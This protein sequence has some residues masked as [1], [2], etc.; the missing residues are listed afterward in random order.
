MAAH[1]LTTVA[2]VRAFLQTPGVDTE[3]DAIAQT[4]ISALSRAISAHCEQE[5]APAVT[6]AE[7]E[8]SYEC[9]TLLCNL[10]PYS[11]RTLTAVDVSDDDGTTWSSFLTS[12]VRRL[13]RPAIHGVFNR[14]KF[15]AHPQGD[16]VRV[17]G[18][19][20]YEEVPET[21]AHVCTIETALHLRRDVA[22][23][24][25]TL[26]L[27]VQALERPDALSPVAV[28]LLLPFTRM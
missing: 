14:L 2:A 15:R 3:Q 4:I 28:G 13:P 22:A 7:R 10:A 25:T 24:S 11:L 8:F 6:S 20:G 27:D 9:G 19:W 5:F 1:D 16:L 26:N 12:E 17:S 23:F 18:A 21:V